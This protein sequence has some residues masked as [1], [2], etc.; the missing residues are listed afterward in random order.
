MNRY[1]IIAGVLLSVALGGGLLYRSISSRGLEKKG[2]QE[3]QA[4]PGKVTMPIKMQA[5]NGVAVA[6]AKKHQKE[7]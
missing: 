5:E 2:L 3:V 1:A 7:L 6:T 4:K